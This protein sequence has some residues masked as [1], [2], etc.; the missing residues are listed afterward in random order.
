MGDYLYTAALEHKVSELEKQNS[1][2][3]RLL[4]L[5][6]DDLN[7]YKDYADIGIVSRACLCK[8]CKTRD[9]TNR[10]CRECEYEYRNADEVMKLIGD[11]E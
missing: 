6:V 9:I 1:E 4:K 10:I 11:D 7:E 8:S 3:R 5:A 2:L